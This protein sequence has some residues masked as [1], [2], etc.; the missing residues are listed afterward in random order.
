MTLRSVG[1]VGKYQ[2]I[3]EVRIPQITTHTALDFAVLQ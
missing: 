2:R 3:R 1:R